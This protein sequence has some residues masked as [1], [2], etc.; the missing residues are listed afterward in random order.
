MRFRNLLCHVPHFMKHWVKISPEVIWDEI[1]ALKTKKVKLF[2]VFAS[3]KNNPFLAAFQASPSRPSGKSSIHIKTNIVHSWNHT[4]RGK[5]KYLVTKILLLV[6]WVRTWHGATRAR[7]RVSAM[8]DQRMN[9]EIW[10]GL[11]RLT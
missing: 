3:Q 9:T 4:Y 7:Y 10:R 5:S 11:S 2:S 1:I 6:G 8:E